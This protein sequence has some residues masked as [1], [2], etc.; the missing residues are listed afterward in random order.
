MKIQGWD[1]TCHFPAAVAHVEPHQVSC[2]WQQFMNTSKGTTTTTLSKPYQNKR[3]DTMTQ[4]NDMIT[5]L[6]R[7]A[8]DSVTIGRGLGDLGNTKLVPNHYSTLVPTWQGWSSPTRPPPGCPRP[9]PPPCSPRPAPPRWRRTP[10][11]RTVTVTHIRLIRDLENIYSFEDLNLTCTTPI[12]L[13]MEVNSKKISKS[14]LADPAKPGA[15]LQ[16]P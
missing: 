10:A 4:C 11:C 6:G 15:A 7:M 2:S 13:E 1:Q 9:A 12:Y 8:G 5:H 14:L 3:T 16:T